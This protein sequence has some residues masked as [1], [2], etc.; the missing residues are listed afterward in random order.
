MKGSQIDPPPPE[1]LP[2]KIPALLGLKYAARNATGVTRGF[3]SSMI[4]TNKSIFP[5]SLLFTDRQV[6]GLPRE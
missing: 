6:A 1:K 3:S 5:H 4:G 2:S